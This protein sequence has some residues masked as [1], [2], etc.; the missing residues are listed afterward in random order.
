MIS[1]AIAISIAITKASKHRKASSTVIS[2]SFFQFK[3]RQSSPVD[4][5]LLVDGSSL[6]LGAPSDVVERN[7]CVQLHVK[8]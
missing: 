5:V 8:F 6:L 4:F 2:Y 3:N 7:R 1:H